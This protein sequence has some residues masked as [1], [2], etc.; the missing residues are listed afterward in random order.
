[1]LQFGDI[2]QGCFT[3]F[4]SFSLILFFSPSP[5]RPSLFSSPHLLSDKT[6][7]CHMVCGFEC[8]LLGALP[9]ERDTL[10]QAFSSDKWQVPF[11]SG[12][13]RQPENHR[14]RYTVIFTA[15]ASLRPVLGGTTIW[16]K[17]WCST[18]EGQKHVVIVRLLVLPCFSWLTEVVVTTYIGKAPPHMFSLMW[19][20]NKAIITGTWFVLHLLCLVLT[21]S[22][23]ANGTTQGREK[24]EW[25]SQAYLVQGP[26]PSCHLAP[27]LTIGG[28][29]QG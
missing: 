4:R 11:P 8:I 2:E 20:R 22:Q 17:D 28:H 14:S 25:E 15:H 13:H 9:N 24:A 5:P 7:K 23:P 26:S 3:L 18:R 16:H 19:I 12:W 29:E 10:W 27:L 1:M 6:L 21:G